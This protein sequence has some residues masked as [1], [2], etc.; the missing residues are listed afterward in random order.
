MEGGGQRDCHINQADERA[1]A[2]ILIETFGVR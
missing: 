1:E 2:K